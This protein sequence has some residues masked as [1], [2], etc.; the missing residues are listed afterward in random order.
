MDENKTPQTIANPEVAGIPAPRTM[1][2]PGAPATPTSRAMKFI[3]SLFATGY[4][5]I[6]AFFFLCGT[7]MIVF[8]A[9]ELWHAI[10]PMA[11][12]PF[13]TRFVKVLE[14][15]GLLTIA[16]AAFELGQTIL[17][18]EVRRTASMSAP[19]RVRRFLSRFLVVVIVSLSIECLVAVFQYIH[20][21][22]ER[23]PEAASIGIAA[24][25]LLAAWGIF[26]KL[27]VTAEQ[28]EPH[29][30]QIAKAEDHQI[31]T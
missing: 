14:C 16:V 5:V 8:G 15:I 26:I 24:A 27:N 30:M 18:E 17:E 25:L 20:T 12:V 2:G 22:P 28:L 3:Q 6:I 29:A 31:E 4:L 10:S 13:R 9:V 11:E 7:S 23:L 1:P 21:S 19:T